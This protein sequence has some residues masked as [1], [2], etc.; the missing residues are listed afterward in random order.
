MAAADDPNFDPPSFGAW[1]A[2]QLNTTA[3][4]VYALYPPTYYTTWVDTNDAVDELF[5][6]P[7]SWWDGN[8]TQDSSDPFTAS[9]IQNILR[10]DNTIE[11]SLFASF[12]INGFENIK[13]E[14]LEGADLEI[15]VNSSNW[16]RFYLVVRHPIL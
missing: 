3:Y 4:D 8:T 9:V 2:G 14:S 5:K 13:D 12:K 10:L 11:N 16:G 7:D 1:F 6:V 15:A